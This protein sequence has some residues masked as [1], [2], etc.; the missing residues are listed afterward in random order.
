M[1]AFVAL[2]CEMAVFPCSGGER[3]GLVLGVTL[4]DNTFLPNSPHLFSAFKT[5]PW[6]EVRAFS[7]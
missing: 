5:V 2:E 7:A 4:T 3:P 1:V 6:A